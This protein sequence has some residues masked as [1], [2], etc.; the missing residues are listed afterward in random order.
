MGN[1]LKTLLMYKQDKFIDVKEHLLNVRTNCGPGRFREGT[2]KQCVIL[3][4]NMEGWEKSR[5]AGRV[6]K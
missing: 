5:E 6:G 1:S 4:G 3:T 2:G